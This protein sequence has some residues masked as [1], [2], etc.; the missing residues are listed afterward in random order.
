[1]VGVPAELE[2]YPCLFGFF[3][4]AGLMVKEYG[5]QGI[6]GGQVGEALP[7]RIGPVVP[8]DHPDTAEDSG[9]IFQ[10]MNAGIRVES[11][12]TV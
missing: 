7:E 4:M 6:R 2:V 12:G 1:M 11:L 10:Q 9:R 3:E 5:E 8:A